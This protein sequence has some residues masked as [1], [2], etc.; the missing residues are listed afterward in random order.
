MHFELHADYQQHIIRNKRR[1]VLQKIIR[2]LSCV[3]I[4]CTTYALILPAITMEE[5]AFCGLEEHIHSEECYQKTSVRILSCSADQAEIHKHDSNCYGDGGALVCHQADYIAH[6]HNELCYDGSGQLICTWPVRDVHV[7]GED[8]YIPGETVETVLH[9][10]NAQCYSLEKG[11]L[12]CTLEEYEGHTHNST[13]YVPGETCICTTEEQHKHSDG[14]YTYPLICTQSTEA[15]VHGPYC[16]SPGEL[17]CT[18]ME[19]HTHE[20]GCFTESLICENMEADHVHEENCYTKELNCTVEQNH[21]HGDSCYA[22]ILV[23]GM[24]EGQT[25]VHGT[26]CYAAEPV[27][28]CQMPENHLHDASCYEQI[29][30]CDLQ[31]DPG[32]AHGDDCYSWNEVTVCG[33]ESGQPEPTES[34][35]LI[36]NCTEPVAQTHVH[37]ETC[38]RETESQVTVVCGN[39]DPDHVHTAECYVMT[40]GLEEHTHTLACY[41]DP[42]AD[43]ETA[44]VWEATFAHVQL[45]RDWPSDV[46]AI[47]ETQLGYTESTRNYDVWADDTLHGYTRY[48]AWFGSPHGDWCAMFVSFCLHYADV[49]GMPLHS[50][51]RPWIEELTELGLYHRAEVYA[52]KAGD[53][54]FYDWDDDGLSDHVGIVAEVQEAQEHIGAGIK[55]IEGNSSNMVRYVHYTMDDPVILGY[56]E[57]PHPEESA[58]VV[59]KS[60]VLYT[61]SSCET[62]AEEAVQITITGKIPED[63]IVRAYPVMPETSMEV[64]CAYDISILLPDSTVF[65]PEEGENLTVCLRSSDLLGLDRETEVFYFPPEGK[66]VPVEF[67]ITEDSICFTANNFPVYAVAIPASIVTKTAVIYTDATYQTPAEDTTVITLSGILPEE[68]EVRAYPTVVEA[69]LDVVCAYDITIFL[70]DGSV[71]EPGAGEAVTVSMEGPVLENAVSDLA[72]YHISEAGEPAPVEAQ[73]DEGVVSFDAEHFSVYAVAKTEEY[74]ISAIIDDVNATL[75]F[76]PLTYSRPNYETLCAYKINITA[77]FDYGNQSPYWGEEKMT[78]TIMSGVFSEKQQIVVCRIDDWGNVSK[79]EV[80]HDGNTVQFVTTPGNCV[81]GF[82]AVLAPPE[83]M[84]SMVLEEDLVITE[85]MYVS[86]DVTIDLNGHTIRPAE[87]YTDPLFEVTETGTLTILD[88]KAGQ[89]SGH[90]LTYS[91]TD[92]NV[93]DSSTR[94]TSESTVENTV[95]ASGGIVAG[96]GPVIR[97]TGGKVNIESGMIHEGTGRA[98]DASGGS[99]V[100]LNG[101]H[102]YGFD[103]V[104]DGGAIYIN[105]GELNLSGTVVASNHAR[106]YGGGIYALN[107]AVTMDG[108]VISGNTVASALDSNGISGSGA[109]NANFG[110]GGIAVQNCNFNLSAGYITNNTSCADGYWGGG[111]GILCRDTTTL[112]M[113]G[114]YVTGNRANAGGGIKT[115]D[116]IDSSATVNITGGYI[117]SNLATY[118]EGGGIA[119]GGGDK[120]YVSAGYI[121]NNT[122]QSPFDWGGGGLF[123][124]N[125]ASLYIER[126]L[127]TENTSGGFGGGIAGCST[128]RMHISITEGGAIYNNHA[129]GQNMAGGG[130]TKSEDVKYGMNSPVFMRNGYQDIFSALNCTVEGGML[131]G[132]PALWTGSCDGEPVTSNSAEDLIHS[133]YILGLTAQADADEASRSMASVFITGNHSNTHGGGILCNGYM[134]M[135]EP[136]TE[137][138]YVGARIEVAAGKEYLDPDGEPLEIPTDPPFTFIIGKEDGSVVTTGTADQ[139]G[140]IFF[141][142]RLPFNS[143]GTFTYY[144]YEQ[145]GSDPT[146]LYDQTRYRLTVTTSMRKINNPAV[147][148]ETWQ[149]Y[150]DSIAVVKWDRETETWLPHVESFDPED[151]DKGP[152]HLDLG[153]A[154]VNH[155]GNTKSD[156]SLTVTKVWNCHPSVIPESI[157]VTLMQNGQPYAS[158]TSTVSLMAE[159]QW[160]HTWTELPVTDQAGMA[161]AYSVQEMALDNFDVQYSVAV[162]PQDGNLKA[163]ITNTLKT[164]SLD[165]SKVSNHSEPIP[166]EG[167]VFCLKDSKGQA[168]SFSKDSQTGTYILV[169]A[170]NPEAHVAQLVTDENGKLVISGLP[171]GTYTLEETEA[172]FGFQLAKPETVILGGEIMESQ[173]VHTMT[174]VDRLVEYEL[175]ETGGPGNFLNTTVG[176]L[177]MLVAVVLL[178]CKTKNSRREDGIP[179]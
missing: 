12:I 68:A 131:G 141:S 89:G 53:L 18:V 60:A 86:A 178:Y 160:T 4:F 112:N 179:A 35:D 21:S 30:V 24:E 13:C 26:E 66:P 153:D 168:L 32:H 158:E 138:M 85:K 120:A 109:E 33:L 147:N 127:V 126:A 119:I 8:C 106:N 34:V 105:G 129:E 102:I 46:V 79:L 115:I 144:I 163:T 44:A 97:V 58:A 161:Y 95:S 143:E 36:L 63:A 135:G 62:V 110:G 121:N 156:T 19:G 92:S 150:I 28:N 113:S 96:A 78:V 145:P 172:P 25:H 159:N 39:G 116:Y 20:A 27:L 155:G 29:L 108:G 101:G 118:G 3:V 103:G 54:I 65:E 31:E 130:S 136:R 88:S 114:G 117:C 69:G 42:N 166:L 84:D 111:G 1:S 5:Q 2:I 122:T 157:S 51:V 165:I 133:E 104:T 11:D 15:H 40:C 76:E 6:S 139:T 174:V 123:V 162:D 151:T 14:C 93:T 67:T 7:H 37:D 154:F 124:A 72:V 176:L 82:F 83:S 94:K 38:F 87:G 16:Y 57:L 71:Y 22:S 149:C 77:H 49:E 128:A 169:Q 177:L 152:I 99:T 64:I 170:D 173:R 164:Y 73:I 125:D 175:P 41:S 81:Q 74:K 134:V 55:A 137:V 90:S 132:A 98:I 23:C 80:T 75:E 91:V 107:C 56:S 70:P 61:D 140:K 43:L 171:A 48:G 100:N 148:V 52:P 146:V 45:T 17:L 10:H 50:G 47:A 59:E 9:E 142:G 167:A